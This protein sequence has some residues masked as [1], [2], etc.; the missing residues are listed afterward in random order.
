MY[1]TKSIKKSATK[2]LL[3]NVSFE[4]HRIVEIIVI[5]KIKSTYRNF[6]IMNK[7][8]ACY[9]LS[10]ENYTEYQFTVYNL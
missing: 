3:H 5:A 9:S 2:L 4:L 1:T 6:T 7:I 8:T 10:E